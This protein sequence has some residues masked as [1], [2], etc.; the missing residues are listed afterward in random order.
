MLTCHEK[1]ATDLGNG[2]QND[3]QVLS[4]NQKLSN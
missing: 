4:H 1:H 3:Y 2:N